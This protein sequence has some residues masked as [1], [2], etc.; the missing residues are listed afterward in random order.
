MCYYELKY[1]LSYTFLRPP[2]ISDE[3]R[4]RFARHLKISSKELNSG[5]GK[6]CGK[7][8]RLCDRSVRRREFE[9]I[10][11]NML[12]TL[13]SGDLDCVDEE[14]RAAVTKKYCS[15]IFEYRRQRI[16]KKAQQTATKAKSGDDFLVDDYVW[17]SARSRKLWLQRSEMKLQEKAGKRRDPHEN[18]GDAARQEEQKDTS[19][20]IEQRRLSQVQ[21]LAARR[22]HSSL[23]SEEVKLLP[24]T[25]RDDGS[26]EK[27]KEKQKEKD[28][29]APLPQEYRQQQR[30]VD[31]TYS[32]DDDENDES[33]GSE[34]KMRIYIMK[35]KRSSTT[36]RPAARKAAVVSL[37]RAI[38]RRERRRRWKWSGPVSN[39]TC[40]R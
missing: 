5:R 11:S 14:R 7:N 32:D 1:N 34:M 28:V 30:E 16:A 31:T 22:L 27:Q 37:P 19:G 4:E 20:M 36:M 33:D 39:L 40:V 9:H 15:D 12:K 18:G 2:V 38:S 35:M 6:H 21:S 13:L 8:A 29:V 3:D 10:G 24:A 17:R 26:A 25:W 23:S